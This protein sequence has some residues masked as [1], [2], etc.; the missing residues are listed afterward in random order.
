MGEQIFFPPSKKIIK[1][2]EKKLCKKEVQSIMVFLT[3]GL[4][5]FVPTFKRKFLKQIEKRS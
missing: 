5:D 1:K 2:I 4:M 3:H